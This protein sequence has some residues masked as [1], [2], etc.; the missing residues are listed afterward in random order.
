MVIFTELK[1]FFKSRKTEHVILSSLALFINLSQNV[2]ITRSVELLSLKPN[3]EG[4][5]TLFLFTNFDMFISMFFQ[6]PLR[7]NRGTK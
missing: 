5:K 7:K 1:F 2:V 3:C 4:V 6:T